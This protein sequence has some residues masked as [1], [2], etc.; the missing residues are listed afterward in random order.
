MRLTNVLILKRT[1]LIT[2]ALTVFVF[3]T[4]V[5][6][7]SH[8]IAFAESHFQDCSSVVWRVVQT[9]TA[10][11]NGSIHI[12]TTGN[13]LGDFDSHN[14]STFCGEYQA[15][16]TVSDGSGSSSFITGG[17]VRVE[18]S[19]GTTLV[20]TSISALGPNTTRTFTTSVTFAFEARAVCITN[21]PFV[22]NIAT[23]N[24]YP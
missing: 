13:L 17:I 15:Q 5:V 7:S 22:R 24:Y 16:C 20:S 2:F 14:H 18:D 4:A 12:N 1:R 11:V 3:A 9:K 8:S 23:T 6:V 19:N 21:N 10:S